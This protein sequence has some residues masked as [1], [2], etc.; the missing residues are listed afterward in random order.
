MAI[1]FTMKFILVGSDDVDYY[2]SE[3]NDLVGGGFGEVI[4]DFDVQSR[5]RLTREE[6]QEYEG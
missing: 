6:S 3:I 2:A 5:R 4:G 1:E